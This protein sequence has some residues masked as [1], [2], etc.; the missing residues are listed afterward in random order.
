MIEIAGSHCRADEVHNE[1]SRGDA[2]DAVDVDPRRDLDHVHADHA[3]LF[4][5]SV[6]QLTGLHEGDASGAR[7]GDSRRDRRVHAVEVYGQIVTA[8]GGDA[9]EDCPHADLM[10]LIGS[11]EM[12]AVGLRRLD[13]LDPRAPSPAQADLKNLADMRHLGGS[14]DRTRIALAHAVDVIAPIDVL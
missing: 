2:G 10:E 11:D 4:Y 13:L 6:D 14:A 1:P 7:P 9:L 3:P 12:R 8:P 5:K